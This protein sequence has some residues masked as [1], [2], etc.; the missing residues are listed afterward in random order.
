MAGA[1]M[2]LFRFSLYVF[3]PTALMMYYSDPDWYNKYV[4]PLK[5]RFTRPDLANKVTRT[6]L[7]CVCTKVTL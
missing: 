4:Y 5:D 1:S 7:S 2:E 6:V 3:F